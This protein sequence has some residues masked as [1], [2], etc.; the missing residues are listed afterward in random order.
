MNFIVDV[1]GTIE[2]IEEQFQTYEKSAEVSSLVNVHMPEPNLRI[3][4][5][6][7]K[8]LL[9]VTAL[10]FA[11]NVPLCN[12][13]S[14]LLVKSSCKVYVPEAMSCISEGPIFLP[15]VVIVSVVVDSKYQ[16][17]VAAPIVIPDA[18]VND[19]YIFCVLLLKVPVNPVKSK[20]LHTL[21]PAVTVTA[22]LAASKNT[23]SV[24]VGTACP[25]AP[26]EVSDH[27]VPA[28]PSQF[29][30]PPTQN[31]F[32]IFLFYHSL[33][34][35]LFHPSNIYYFSCLSYICFE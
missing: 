6:V 10:L 26:P 17:P 9:N 14:P 35:Y 22:P 23:S 28:V 1:D 16:M 32:A 3:A 19:P 15:F 4:V 7:E 11:S 29:A 33:L 20:S 25:P 5:P 8:K 21:F 34:I 13:K 12:I 27:L 30:V 24:L 18:N 2:P 31:L